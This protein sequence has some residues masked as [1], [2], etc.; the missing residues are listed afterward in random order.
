MFVFIKGKEGISEKSGKEY[1]MLTLAQYVEVKGKVKVKLGDYFP[2]RHV[3]LADFEFGDIVECT[4]SEPE[5]MGDYPKL[6]SCEMA[7]Q[8][9]Y[10]EL[11][12]KYQA[13]AASGGAVS[14]KQ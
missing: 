9:P 4:F 13:K 12:A 11:L 5:F 10:V 6:V 7:F 8:S 3:N 1:Q 14:A 2:E